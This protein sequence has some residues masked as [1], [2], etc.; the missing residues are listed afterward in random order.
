MLW[1][2]VN[3]DFSLEN[4]PFTLHLLSLL[5]IANLHFHSTCDFHWNSGAHLVIL[6]SAGLF[7]KTEEL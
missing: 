2:N 1:M 5:L 7:D 4:K 3:A 6:E